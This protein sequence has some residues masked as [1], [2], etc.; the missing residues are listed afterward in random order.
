MTGFY[1]CDDYQEQQLIAHDAVLWCDKRS[2]AW[3]V[4]ILAS[5]PPKSKLLAAEP[6]DIDDNVVWDNVKPPAMDA[7]IALRG[8]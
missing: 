2:S 6:N 7:P 1:I 8:W 4:A 5:P 3:R